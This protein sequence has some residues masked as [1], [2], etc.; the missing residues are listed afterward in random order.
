[1]HWS[2]T[3]KRWVAQITK[4]YKVKHLGCFMTAEA[5]ALAYNAAA[6]ESHGGGAYLNK[7]DEE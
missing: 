2:K 5:A 4:N 6:K 7:I 3:S 1:M